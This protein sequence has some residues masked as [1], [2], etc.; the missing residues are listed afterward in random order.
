MEE[1]DAE[2][3]IKKALKHEAL[4]KAGPYFFLKDTKR[5]DKYYSISNSYKKLGEKI[6]SDLELKSLIESELFSAGAK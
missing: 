5:G 3:Y 2:T 1:F 6:Q 4:F